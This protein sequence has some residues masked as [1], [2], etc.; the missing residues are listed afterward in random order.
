MLFVFSAP[1]GAGKTTIVDSLKKS[2]AGIGYSI[3]HT[4]RAPRDNE[5]DGIHYH[6]VDKD[7]FGSMIEDGAFVEWAQV[8]G[9]FYGTSYTS[10][11]AQISKGL[12]VILDV[13]PQGAKNIKKRYNDCILVFIL[14]PT[15]D[16]LQKRLKE[17]GTEN[18][19]VLRL[20]FNK[21]VNEIANCTW[22]DYIIINDDLDK[23]I[24]QAQS[25]IVS[26]RCRT[27][28]QLPKVRKVF[29]ID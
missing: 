12:D 17:R 25:I 16:V 9:N 27:S 6:F 20:R 28:N 8:Y 29:G 3:S 23:A 22:Y 14:P 10:I 24:A 19:E 5:R 21:A 2:L 4:S 11:D 15:L 18:E 7:I 1:S 26:G 13:D